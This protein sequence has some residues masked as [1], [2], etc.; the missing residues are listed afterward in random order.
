MSR[1]SRIEIAAVTQDNENCV[2]GAFYV[3]Y[4]TAMQITPEVTLEIRQCVPAA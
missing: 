2:L 1:D 4:D 3:F